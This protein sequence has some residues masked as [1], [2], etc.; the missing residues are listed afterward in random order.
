[1]RLD[2]V[3]RE[4]DRGRRVEGVA[5]ITKDIGAD[6][7]RQRVIS[8]NDPVGAVVVYVDLALAP[9]RRNVPLGRGGP[10][11]TARSVCSAAA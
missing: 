11:T 7:R 1:M 4:L 9:L 6:L 8:R 10:I 2:H 5:A 3:E